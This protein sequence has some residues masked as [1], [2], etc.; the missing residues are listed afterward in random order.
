[1]NYDALV[2]YGEQYGT[3]NVPSNMKC[4]LPDG[5]VI[6]LGQWLCKQRTAK[7]N[8][9]LNE[10]RLFQLQKLVDLKLVDWSIDFSKLHMNN[11]RWDAMYDLMVQYGDEHE[12]NCNALQRRYGP[13]PCV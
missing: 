5:K 6:S 1:M 3:C 2:C 7:K 12:G 8:R 13:R 10:Y 4:K 9:T 11:D